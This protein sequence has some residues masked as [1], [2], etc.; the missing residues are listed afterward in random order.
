M[1]NMLALIYHKTVGWLVSIFREIWFGLILSKYEDGLYKVSPEPPY[2]SQLADSQREKIEGFYEAISDQL[3]SKRFGAPDLNVFSF[4]AWRSCGVVGIQ[5]VLQAQHRSGFAKS[6]M[7][8]IN[9][10]LED[11]GYDLSTDRGWYH[12]ALVAIA[13]RH[14]VAGR[15]SKF[16]SASQ[17]ACLVLQG[18][19]ILASIKSERGG[20]LL[21]IWG[22][23]I[24]N[25]K[26]VS[27]LIHDPNN[28]AEDGKSKEIA[29]SS[30]KKLSTR[31]IVILENKEGACARPNRV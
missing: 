2:I 14:G 28:F 31:R 3:A 10:G 21:L 20:H 5:M 4:W 9:E 23:R 27:F 24:R 26:L 1:R 7:D 11:D 15:L 25:G 16:V 12:A 17:I 19:Y 29:R 6:T 18:N 22:V 8:L 30:F 13:Q